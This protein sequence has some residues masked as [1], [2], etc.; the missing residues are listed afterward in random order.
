MKRRDPLTSPTGTKLSS[1][2]PLLFQVYSRELD[3]HKN[4]NQLNP[5]MED[6]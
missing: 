2:V 6:R 3:G 4:S 1:I 5:G